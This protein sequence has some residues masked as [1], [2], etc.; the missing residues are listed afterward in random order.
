MKANELRIGNWVLDDESDEVQI[1]SIE[2][3]MSNYTYRWEWLK[4]YK[5]ITLTEQWLIDFGFE[6]NDYSFDKG[7]FKITWGQRIVSTGVRSSFFL[8][9]EIPE[10]YKIR[11]DTVHTLQNLY[12]ALKNDELLK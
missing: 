10:S 6:D 2:P 8:D 7:D 9:G 3:I 1:E 12:F 4:Y 11:I 5:P